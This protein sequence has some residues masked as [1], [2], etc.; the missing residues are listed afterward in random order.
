MKN[1][2]FILL[3]AMLIFSCNS[4][5]NNS[6]ESGFKTFKELHEKD[7]GTVTFSMP[8]FIFKMFV[9]SD[10]KDV[11]DAVNEINDIN[12]LIQEKADDTFT[13]DLKKHI[14]NDQYKSLM[15][16]NEKDAEINVV[17]NGKDEK[18]SEV[19][20]VINDNKKNSCVLLKIGGNFDSNSVKNLS[21]G[22]D[23]EGVSK[24]R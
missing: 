14:L 11:K 23:I 7:N 18:I 13:S 21:E 15:K 12:F 1:T 10:K 16:F 4:G 5:S 20:I 8:A 6:T 3:S 17:A 22:I 2:I 19:V 24:Y 9:K